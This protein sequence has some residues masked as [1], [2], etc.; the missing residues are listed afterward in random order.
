MKTYR[1]LEK[2]RRKH[3]ITQKE[4]GKRLNVSKQ[5]IWDIED[6]RRTLSYK[7]AFNIAR[8]LGERPDVIFLDDFKNKY[9]D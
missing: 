1:K 9:R 2:F 3:N 7:T 5:Y 6:G 4:L 8:V